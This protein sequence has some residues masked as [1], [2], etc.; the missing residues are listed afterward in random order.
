MERAFAVALRNLRRNKR[1]NLATVA[2]VA[3]GFAGLIVIG[4]YGN[5][6]E[7]F[8]RTNAVYLQHSGHVTVYEKQGLFLSAAEPLKKQLGPAAQEAILGWAKQ[9]G[10]V[11]FAARYLR[12]VGLAG[13]GCGTYPTMLLGVEPWALARA[14]Q[15]REVNKWSHEIAAPLRGKW[16]DELP[17]VNRPAMVAGGLA[18]LLEKPRVYEEAVGLPPAPQ[19]LHCD[20]KERTQELAQDANVQLAGINYDGSLSALDT[21]MVGTYHPSETLGEDGFMMTTLGT[22]Q[23]LYATDRVTYIGLYLKSPLDAHAVAQD[24]TRALSDKGLQVD[25]LP[26]DD[27]DSKPYYVGTMAF[28][29]AVAGFMTGLVV[30]VL[31][32]TVLGAMTLTILE[33]T[34]ELGTLR[35]LGFPRQALIGLVV[36]EAVVLSA[37]GLVLGTVLGV[38]GC[39][40][41]NA[42]GI[43]FA[44]PGVPGTIQLILVP[45]GWICAIQAAVVLPCLCFAAWLVVRAQAKRNIVDLLTA[46]TG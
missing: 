10:R 29:G 45:A 35:A 23:E 24:M 30:L 4:G 11:E 31:A 12:G 6:V 39:F 1:R 5:R 15:H 36:R 16:L 19:V 26:F 46:Q 17:A 7:H 34:R 43:R 28:L 40:A 8:L 13:N 38:S 20:G 21:E 27:E 44:P 2:A 18:K 37:L 32:L 42:A 22:L 14:R 25:A 33:R 9:D 41:V 3:L